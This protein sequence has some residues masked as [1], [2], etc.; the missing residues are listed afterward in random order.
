MCGLWRRA[1]RGSVPLTACVETALV[2]HCGFHGMSMQ[3]HF[4]TLTDKVS[5][6]LHNK[7]QRNYL[8]TTALFAV[9]CIY[10]MK[11]IKKDRRLK[12]LQALGKLKRE[13]FQ[14][15]K[16]K[17]LLEP[18]EYSRDTAT[19]ILSIS[20]MEIRQEIIKGK[21]TRPSLNHIR[22]NGS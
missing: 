17:C 3:E 22:R 7:E 10:G 18:I 2:P 4:Q 15:K 13:E 21:V 19:Q 16:H 6:I 14:N 12:E 1:A 11:K 20:G 9:G 8:I 5:S